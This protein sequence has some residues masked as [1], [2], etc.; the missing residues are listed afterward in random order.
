MEQQLTLMGSVTLVNQLFSPSSESSKN[1]LCFILF[2][3]S[4]SNEIFSLS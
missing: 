1:L 3:M 4:K 2:F